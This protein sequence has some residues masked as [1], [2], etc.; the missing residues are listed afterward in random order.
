MHLELL[1]EEPSMEATLE[2]LLPRIVPEQTFS[3]HVHRGKQDLLRKL[4]PRLRAYGRMAWPDLRIVVIVDRDDDDCADLKR[5]LL[6]MCTAAGCPALCRIAIEELEAWF[7]GDIEAVRAAYPR[8]S[9][10]L[11]GQAKYRDPDAITGGT[12]EALERELGR[13]GYYKG[14][15][16]K[17]EV[18][19]R[20][21]AQMEPQRNSSRSFQVLVD[22]LLRRTQSIPGG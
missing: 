18:A 17:V 13:A 7:F 14:G 11:S 20:I 9:A 5:R 19:R 4:T 15:M 2:E 21:A 1:V 16:P 6:D 10:R 12:W 3:I 22:G 8:V